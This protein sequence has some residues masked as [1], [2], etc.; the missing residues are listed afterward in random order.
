MGTIA[1]FRTVFVGAVA[2][3]AVG[4]VGA[5]PPATATSVSTPGLA[6]ALATST[7]GDLV[8]AVAGL[9]AGARGRVVVTGPRQSARTPWGF[10]AV[11]PGSTRFV[12]LVPGVYTLTS[13]T[14]PAVGGSAAPSPTRAVVR[15]V[16][17]R[18]TTQVVRYTFIPAGTTMTQGALRVRIAG[19]PVGA[20][21][22]VVV[23]GPRQRPTDPSTFRAVLGATRQLGP[24]TPGRYTVAAAAVAV[25]GGRA[26]PEAGPTTI[27][28][29]A[30]AVAVAQVT[31]RVIGVP[32]APSDVV[33]AA[34]NAAATLS[35][36][37]PAGTGGA[38]ITR[39]V[40]T[41]SPGGTGCATGGALSCVVGGLSNGTAYTFTVR[42]TNQQNLTSPAS[43]PSAAVVP[44]API[45]EPGAPSAVHATAGDTTA[46]VA[47]QRPVS[48][49]GA[50]LTEYVATSQPEGHTCSVASPAVTCTVTGLT[51][52]TP[53]TFTVRATNQ[54]G[55]T[56]VPS[57]ASDPVTPHVI[58]YAPATPTGVVAVPDANAARVTWQEPASDGGSAITSYR[59]T[60]SP[61]AKTCTAIPP[62]L[63]CTVT[64]LNYLSGYRF[65][66]TAINAV[67]PSPSSPSSAF[68][69]P[70]DPRDME[71]LSVGATRLLRDIHTV[72]LRL[73]DGGA[74]SSGLWLVQT[75]FEHLLTLPTPPGT[76]P[77]KYRARLTTLAAFAE[78]ASD[79]YWDYPMEAT[80]RY[81]VLREETTPILVAINDW[82]GTSFELPPTP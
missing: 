38:P 21:G 8:V 49:G 17:G 27:T 74:V 48:N 40:V 75:D 59:V 69:V 68:I 7:R 2:V 53:Y 54:A 33:A 52:G 9:P 31:Y 58:V 82:L 55:L 56:S 60:S 77:A 18:A 46:T 61:G 13:A 73:R 26:V 80:A 79:L 65:T 28:V 76:D 36:Q 41:A 14:V 42:A 50:A 45:T 62:A 19:L 78:D 25:P 72:D 24:L 10:L 20:A 5:A 22:S 4:L 57:A 35:W 11:V 63:G 6:T 37:P 29:A 47:W 16:P 32:D 64:G 43:A 44:S 12:N 70:I 3:L 1:R 34:G 51:N 67:G 71:A 81:V 30:R 23:T 66:V 15:I 39:Y